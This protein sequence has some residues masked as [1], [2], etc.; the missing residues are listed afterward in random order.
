M[1]LKYI[2]P[3][4]ALFLLVSCQKEDP[5]LPPPPCELENWGHVHIENFQSDRY[6]VYFDGVL[7]V[8]VGDGISVDLMKFPAGVYLVEFLNIRTGG[9]SSIDDFAVK[10]C[11]TNLLPL[12]F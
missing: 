12:I 11:E 8:T 7:K 5:D 3:A 2:L 9:I 10:R 1:K 4:V 6:E